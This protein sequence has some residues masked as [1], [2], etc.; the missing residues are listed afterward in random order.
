L[1][2]D[3]NNRQASDPLRILVYGYGN[4]GRQ[5]D[6]MGI[7]LVDFIEQWAQ[8]NRFTN[9]ETD[10]NY[11]LNIEDAERISKFDL[12]VFCDAS[13]KDIKH[14]ELEEVVPDLR[15][16]F[17]MHAVTPSFVVGLC[18]RIFE[19]YPKSY[20]LHIKGYSWEFMQDVTRRAGK[21]LKKAQ[22]ILTSFLIEATTS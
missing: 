17:S 14:A 11:Q 12:V 10:Q 8:E 22:E 21:N 1:I 2:N 13:V 15:T 20:Q 7:Q 16:E 6:S 3:E 5:D 18:H 19:R 4:P 9:I